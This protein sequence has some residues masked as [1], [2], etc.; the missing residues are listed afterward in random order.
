MRGA[1]SRPLP[2]Q[3]V[4]FF[5]SSPVRWRSSP[6]QLAAMFER[7]SGSASA[8]QAVA[9]RDDHSLHAVGGLEFVIDP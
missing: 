8:D 1:G 9:H 2:P 6:A 5:M 7:V 3:T 4:S